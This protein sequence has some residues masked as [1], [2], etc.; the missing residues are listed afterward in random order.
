M[1]IGTGVYLA[2]YLQNQSERFS[3]K[4]ALSLNK[5]GWNVT[6][7]SK[8]MTEI[9]EESR[10]SGWKV[11]YDSFFGSSQEGEDPS[12]FSEN[13]LD[14]ANNKTETGR[15]L[16]AKTSFASTAGKKALMH[17]L[18]SDR[19][20]MLSKLQPHSVG[21]S[22]RNVSSDFLPNIRKNEGDDSGSIK[23]KEWM[24]L[25]ENAKGNVEFMSYASDNF[26]TRAS[27]HKKS[28]IPTAQSSGFIKGKY[29][30]YKF[31]SVSNVEKM[32]KNN[33]R[34]EDAVRILDMAL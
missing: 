30:S 20:L 8:N 32:M 10:L 24:E 21:D 1:G 16:P 26:E 22:Q 3:E 23:A 18:K 6:Q 12:V 7:T 15:N 13:N 9:S 19:Y 29:D 27:K 34:P 11:A 14:V 2:S 17:G 33:Y 5:H 31:F 25:F 28:R 4:K